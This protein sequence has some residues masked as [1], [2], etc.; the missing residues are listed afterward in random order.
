MPRQDSPSSAA[1]GPEACS[2]PLTASALC[3]A[4][5]GIGPM[6]HDR[7][8]SALRRLPRGPPR[9]IVLL[10]S[11]RPRRN[12]LTSM[13][14]RSRGEPIPIPYGIDAESICRLG[15]PP[16][17][18]PRPS[19]GPRARRRRRRPSR[20][21]PRPRRDWTRRGRCRSV[22]R[23]WGYSSGRSRHSFTSGRATGAPRAPR[24]TLVTLCPHS[25]ARAS[26]S[27]SGP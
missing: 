17:S 22:R 1:A 26:R 7:A 18:S 24:S 16:G 27:R 8:A 11:R 21:P 10:S 9:G 25:E 3:L 15:D 13:V 5:P 4:R 6:A 19:A 14:K 23:W 20:R 2:P 12:F